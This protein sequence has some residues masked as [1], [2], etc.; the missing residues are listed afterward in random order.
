MIFLEI[1]AHKMTLGGQ[2]SSRRGDVLNGGSGIW[3]DEGLA[4][5]FE[6]E[7]VVNN[8]AHVEENECG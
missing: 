8:R 2:K 1:A 6:A 7:F 4:L 5:L 3:S